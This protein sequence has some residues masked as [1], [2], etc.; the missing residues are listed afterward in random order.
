M[1]KTPQTEAERFREA[2]KLIVSV[3]KTEIE[4]REIAYQKSR[5][6]IRKVKT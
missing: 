5:K 1:N 3:P 4:R 6:A 2:M